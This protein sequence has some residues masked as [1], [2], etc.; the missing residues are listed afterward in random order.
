MVL[1][2]G[3][4]YSKCLWKSTQPRKSPDRSPFNKELLLVNPVACAYI[5]C[6]VHKHGFPAAI[7]SSHAIR[8]LTSM[9]PHTD[10]AKA[11]TETHVFTEGPEGAV[12]RVRG[13][14]YQ[15]TIKE[16]QEV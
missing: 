3:S 1:L 16:V 4:G 7:N 15:A 6:A 2:K 11:E 13:L 10:V 9:F 14:P 8:L 12:L 5:A